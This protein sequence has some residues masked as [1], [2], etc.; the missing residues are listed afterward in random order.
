LPAFGEY[1]RIESVTN[2][3]LFIQIKGGE[4]GNYV[5]FTQYYGNNHN[6]WERQQFAFITD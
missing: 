3:G 1:Y 6:Y 2:S 5:P 4:T